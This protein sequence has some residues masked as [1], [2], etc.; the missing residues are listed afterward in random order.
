MIGRGYTVEIKK[1]NFTK[2]KANGSFHDLVDHGTTQKMV[3]GAVP[4]EYCDSLDRLKEILYYN[5]QIPSNTPYQM[6][7]FA[8]VTLLQAYQKNGLVK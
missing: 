5:K 8:V 4:K 2:S 7:G 3:A 1:R 6:V